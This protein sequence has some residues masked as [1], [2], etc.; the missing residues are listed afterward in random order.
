MIRTG[1][2]PTDTQPQLTHLSEKRLGL[3]EACNVSA[4]QYT[5]PRCEVKTCSL[6]CLNLHKQELKCDGVRDRTKYIPLVKMTRV[7][8]MNDYYFLE[9]C[10]KFVQDRKRDRRKRF[11]CTNRHLPNH[12][13]R[14]QRAAMERGTML[15]ILLQH[16]SKREKNTT[17]L[18]FKSGKIMWRIEWCFPNGSET[19]VFVDENVNEDCKLYDLVDKY[20]QPAEKSNVHGA[21]KLAYYQARGISALQLLL[22]AEG[23]TQCRNR[24]LPLN[25]NDTLRESL[26]GKTVVEFPT[27]YVVFKD[28][29]DQFN[30]VDSDDDME[31]EMHQYKHFIDKSLKHIDRSSKVENIE[32]RLDKMKLEQ[33]NQGNAKN[34]DKP[35][36][37]SFNFLFSDE[38]FLND[39]SESDDESTVPKKGKS[40][41]VSISVDKDDA[42]TSW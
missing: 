22:K 1:P 35:H 10:T 33:I 25:L 17:Y 15:K 34:R 3:C 32:G 6:V 38:K 37:G 42:S 27:I 26:Q 16:F 39:L 14:L 23:I 2:N 19:I 5:C 36:E 31:D 4:A 28:Q 11:T 12:L 20:L 9:E 24:A 7:D 21:A 30:V 8:L 41:S 13:V 29:P 18:D 40:E